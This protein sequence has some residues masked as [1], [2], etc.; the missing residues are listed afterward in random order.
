MYR[1][2]SVIEA[3]CYRR[4]FEGAEDYDLWL[5][6]SRI[7]KLYNL[8]E[9]LTKYRI[10]SD[11]YSLKFSAYR[12]DLDSLVRLV[13]LGSIR[14]TPK[15]FFDSPASRDQI[16]KYLEIYSRKVE[17]N[18]PEI[19]HQ[20]LCAQRF[21]HILEIKHSRIKPA[22]KNFKVL[23]L[24]CKLILFSPVFSLKVVIGKFFR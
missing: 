8:N 10:T 7:G 19:L 23:V 22:L 24:F 3:G 12:S 15:N 1:R 13:N 2:K 14:D 16:R 21:G 6:L 20:L 4:I 17:V 5:R 9:P 11:Q 18:Q